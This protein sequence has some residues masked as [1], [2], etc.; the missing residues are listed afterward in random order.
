MKAQDVMTAP[1]I[2]VAP[3]TPVSAV[4]GRLIERR[5]SAVPGIDGS[6]SVV[7]ILSEGDLLRRSETSTE[8]QRPRWLE[9]LLDSSMQAAELET[10][11][12]ERWIDVDPR[13]RRGE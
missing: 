12:D 3:E 7:G 9:L 11:A 1:A 8:R 4:A 5:I 2:T 6:G 10:L 13:Q